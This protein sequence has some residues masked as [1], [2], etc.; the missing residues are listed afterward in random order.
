MNKSNL[1]KRL[2]WIMIAMFLLQP[3]FSSF[4]NNDHSMQIMPAIELTLS[5]IK[6]VSEELVIDR[7]DIFFPTYTSMQI[8]QAHQ[9][10]DCCQSLD[11]SSC[12][13]SCHYVPFVNRIEIINLKTVSPSDASVYWLSYLAISENPPPQIVI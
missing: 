7:I 4:K 10:M 11:M 2:L 6:S 3:V 9:E 8:S 13:S 5:D 12:L 1:M